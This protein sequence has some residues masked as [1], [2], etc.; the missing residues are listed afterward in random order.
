VSKS[1]FKTLDLCMNAIAAKRG[2]LIDTPVFA[3]AA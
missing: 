1:S 3:F 2:E